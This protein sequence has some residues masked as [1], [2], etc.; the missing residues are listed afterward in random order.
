MLGYESNN[1]VRA[2]FCLA[3][4]LVLGGFVFA[5][6][7][8]FLGPASQSTV[9]TPGGFFGVVPLTVL[10][11]RPEAGSFAS[12]REALVHGAGPKWPQQRWPYETA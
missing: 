8:G 4:S 9:Q 6:S 7:V 3:G 10:L 5:D 2:M 12:G 1:V 11:D